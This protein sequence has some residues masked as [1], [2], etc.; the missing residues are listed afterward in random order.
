MIN[1]TYS[2]FSK[3]FIL[4]SLDKII[5]IIWWVFLL[6]GLSLYIVHSINYQPN[7]NRMLDFDTDNAIIFYAIFPLTAPFVW[8]YILYMIFIPVKLTIDIYKKHTT[9]EL[10]ILKNIIISVLSILFS[11]I[12]YLMY[13]QVLGK[14][15]MNQWNSIFVIALNCFIIIFSNILGLILSIVNNKNIKIHIIYMVIII[16][17]TIIIRNLINTIGNT[18]VKYKLVSEC[19]IILLFCIIIIIENIISL[20]I[21]KRINKIRGNCT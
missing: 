4:N 6:T 13:Y 20:I 1:I 15:N 7:Q 17:S 8:F 14:M 21:V 9:D 3:K 5:L 10:Y 16:I 11:G 18:L 19:S 2:H 12:L